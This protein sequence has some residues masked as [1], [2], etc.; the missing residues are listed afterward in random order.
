MGNVK[1]LTVVV[2]LKRNS[3]RVKDKNFRQLN[4]V[5]LFMRAVRNGQS[6]V[7]SGDADMLAV[8]GAED[9][10]GFVPQ[11]VPWF[12]ERAAIVRND[13]NDLNAEI[14]E[15]CE[16]DL[17]MVLN[18]TSPFTKADTLRRAIA[19][20]R[21]G[22]FDSACSVEALRGRL[23]RHDGVVLNHDPKTCPRT[24]TQA[25]I[26]MESD[27]FWLAHRMLFLNDHRRVGFRPYFVEVSGVEALDV[28]T[29]DDW[30]ICELAAK[31]M[32]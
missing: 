23:W 7:D 22:E 29:E 31:G 2:P 26:Y 24:Q 6:L 20:V 14:A 27:A 32:E 11:G 12:R 10:D 21:S 5:Q 9:V 17:V 30:T 3:Q 18:S 1:T 19:A 25:P 16:T 4:G 8:F 13:S 28:D 15:H